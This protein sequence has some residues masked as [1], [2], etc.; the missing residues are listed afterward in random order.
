MADQCLRS[1]ASGELLDEL[2]GSVDNGSNA[3]MCAGFRQAV[4]DSL[5]DVD[6]LAVSWVSPWITG[7]CAWRPVDASSRT[8]GV[9]A[10]DCRR[11]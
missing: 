2:D 4:D 11:K 1:G 3:R 7:V 10:I 6:T 8:R 9:L 5:L